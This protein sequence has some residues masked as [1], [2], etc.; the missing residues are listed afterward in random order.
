L[1][2]YSA[3]ARGIG[4]DTKSRALVK[5][6]QIGFSNMADMGASRKA[7]IFT[8]SRRTQEYLKSFLEA[9]GYAGQVVLFSGSNSDPH[10]TVACSYLLFWWVTHIKLGIRKIP[11]DARSS[12][13]P[14]GYASTACA[15]SLGIAVGFTPNQ[16][17]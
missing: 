11:M 12:S 15:S 8:E 7:L 10:D 1:D 14:F 5:A 6:L 9:N 4:T 16:I 2:R 17:E 3:W 13:L